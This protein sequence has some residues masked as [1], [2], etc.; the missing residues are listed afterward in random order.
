MPR[1]WTTWATE[2]PSSSRAQR[3]CSTRSRAPARASTS[4]WAGYDLGYNL[5]FAA[6]AMAD[7]SPRAHQHCLE[8][9]FPQFGEVDTT[10]AIIA[11]LGRA[12]Q[13]A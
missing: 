8:V 11:A 1:A 12:P 10:G 7:F 3:S 13:P 4:C 9:T 6:D 5:T 2:T